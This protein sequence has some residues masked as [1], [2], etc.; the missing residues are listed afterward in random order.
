MP[1]WALMWTYWLQPFD[2]VLIYTEFSRSK[3]PCNQEMFV[4]FYLKL[5][6]WVVIILEKSW[7]QSQF[8][9]DYVTSKIYSNWSIFV[10]KWQHSYMTI[11][12]QRQLC[13]YVWYAYTL[14]FSFLF[15][16]PIRSKKC[17]QCS[18]EC[19][20]PSKYKCLL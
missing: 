3:L 17:W 9:S 4:L 5:H 14:I 13:I 20:I 16:I 7:Q 10:A 19:F 11:W 8:H 6:P 18:A 12:Y 15:I 2:T 1:C